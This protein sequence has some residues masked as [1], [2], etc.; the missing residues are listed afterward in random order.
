MSQSLVSFAEIM[1]PSPNGW[2]HWSALP[3]VWGSWHLQRAT[4]PIGANVSVNLSNLP[5][6]IK[7]ALTKWFWSVKTKFC[8]FSESSSKIWS[9][10]IR[11]RVCSHSFQ[12]C[13]NANLCHYSSE[14]IIIHRVFIIISVSNES[15]YTLF[16]LQLR[17]GKVISLS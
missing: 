12:S 10:G 1:T 17:L 2:K 7:Y 13:P 3:E 4:I 6:V 9:L 14:S 16:M 5:P 8:H 11:S 15:F